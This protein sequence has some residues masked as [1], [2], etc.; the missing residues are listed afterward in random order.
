MMHGVGTYKW[1]DGRVY[2]GSYVNDKKNGYGVYMWSDGRTYL[3]QW[4]DGK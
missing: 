1:S 3:G 2:H 4:I